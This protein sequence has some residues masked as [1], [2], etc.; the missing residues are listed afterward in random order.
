VFRSND[1]GD[2]WTVISGD[3][4]AKIDR[5]SFPVMGKYWSIDAVMK[6]VS[7]SQ[8]GTIISLE[9]STLKEGLIYAGTD[10]GIINITDDGGKNWRQ[11]KE[12]PGIPQYTYV[13]DIMASRFDTNV[14]FASFDNILRDDFKPYLL[15]SNDKGKTWESISSDLPENGTVHTIQQDH[16]KPDLLFAGTEFGAFFTTDGGRKWTRLKSGLPDIK[17]CDIAI[18]RR[19]NDLVLAT[20]G[21]GIYILDDY[22]PLRTI[23]S[24]TTGK[25]AVIFPVKD[26]LMYTRTYKGWSR[27]STYY[28]AD[29]PPFGAI[30]TY[31]L[32]K[33]P[34]TLKDL[35]HKKEAELFRHGKP[36][37]QPS[38]DQLQAEELEIPPYLTLTISRENGSV[39][40]KINTSPQEGVNRLS[41]DLRYNSTGLVSTDKFQVDANPS[42]IMVLPGKYFVSLSITFRDTMTE[43]VKPATFNVI[44]LNNTTIV[45]ADR[46]EIVDFYK[47]AAELYRIYQGTQATVSSLKKEITSIMTA[48]QRSS[49]N[50][51]PEKKAAENISNKIDNIIFTFYGKKYGASDEENP[52][53]AVTLEQRLDKLSLSNSS[54][55]G[56]PTA[57]QIKAYNILSDELSKVYDETKQILEV[58]M[59]N[60][61]KAIDALAIPATPN[62]LPEWKK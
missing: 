57:E 41:W 39:I 31:Y 7:T 47:K 59:V 33:A 5:N 9:E 27:G 40:R 35:R 2:S 51:G 49:L 56:S 58:D 1:R 24:D 15:K 60:L 53:M 34:K 8:Y 36:V 17:I 28:T 38:I 14:V 4:T 54:N 48:L 23:N 3:L 12:F 44:L 13:S 16:I 25:D 50:I 55:T 32:K 18:Q 46:N 6:D 61:H 52:P 20:F 21:R 26:A 22:S 11:V 10:D 29:N 19:E 30:F 37:P 43:L 42:G 62:H 45:P